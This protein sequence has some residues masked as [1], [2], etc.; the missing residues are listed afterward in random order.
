MKQ[1]QRNSL[2]NYLEYAIDYAWAGLYEEAI[3][4]LN[5]GLE[6]PPDLQSSYGPGA[7]PLALYYMGWFHSLLGNNKDANEYYKK[8]SLV[9]GSYC[10]P[11]EL[12]SVLVL[13]AAIK[14]N[15]SD[16]KAQYYLGNLLVC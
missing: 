8:A 1:L 15:P 14:A 2:F 4:L 12:E 13:K 9:E 5:I 10:F 11:N 7:K 3:L 6:C 16:A